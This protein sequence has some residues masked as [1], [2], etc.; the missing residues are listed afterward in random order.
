MKNALFWDV[1]PTRATRRSIPED[2]ILNIGIDEELNLNVCL[3]S[4]P[5]DVPS[6]SYP[7]VLIRSSVAH[8]ASYFFFLLLKEIPV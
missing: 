3:R 1:R 7:S 6:L 4:T 8:I 2:G 5:Q